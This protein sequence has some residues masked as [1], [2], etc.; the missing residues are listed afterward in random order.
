MKQAIWFNSQIQDGELGVD[1]DV[2]IVKALREMSKGEL[3]LKGS[4]DT[5]LHMKANVAFYA[6]TGAVL[7]VGGVDVKAGYLYENGDIIIK[8]NQIFRVSNDLGNYVID[9]TGLM[10]DHTIEVERTGFKFLGDVNS[11]IAQD[12]RQ[13]R[14]QV[15]ST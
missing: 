15:V 3:G 11:R 7:R 8:D 13:L 4:K 6:S 5:I 9:V 1:S 10:N 12:Y 2:M 14:M